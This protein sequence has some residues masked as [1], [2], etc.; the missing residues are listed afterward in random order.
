[1]LREV[2]AVLEWEYVPLQAETG[3]YLSQRISITEKCNMFVDGYKCRI[4]EKSRRNTEKSRLF[5]HCW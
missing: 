4:M 5:K 1:M 2:L 3:Q